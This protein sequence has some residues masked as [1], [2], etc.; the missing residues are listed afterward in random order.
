[1]FTII[2]YGS[3]TATSLWVAPSAT[4]AA[5]DSYFASVIGN[6]AAA[7]SASPSVVD[8]TKTSSA[9]LNA[10]G[11]GSDRFLRCLYM[12]LFVIVVGL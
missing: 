12:F 9:S 1:M 10:A 11:L 2:L 7:S 5:W 4:I 6:E 8:G 3:G